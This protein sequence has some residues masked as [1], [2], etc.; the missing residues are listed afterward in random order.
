MEWWHY[1]LI[2]L[3]SVGA[4][5]LLGLL[6]A[7]LIKRFARKGKPALAIEEPF[8]YT[9][10]DLAEEAESN[11]KIAAEPGTGELLPFQTRVWNA[12]Q[13]EAKKLPPDI[14][15]DFEQVYINIR[16][17]NSI[18]RL[19]TQFS[20][21]PHD[22]DDSYKKLCATIAELLERIKSSMEQSGE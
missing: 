19:S 20:H 14:R 3:V 15:E 10:L 17:A 8:K 6:F 21:R 7:R 22:L 9:L 2:G 5:L 11:R 1:L 18:V 12:Y 4:G 13:D 16:L